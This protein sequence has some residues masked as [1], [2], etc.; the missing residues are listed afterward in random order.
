MIQISKIRKNA[1]LIGDVAEK[2]LKPEGYKHYP[3]END[4]RKWRGPNSQ[5][6]YPYFE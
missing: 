4:N 2:I 5:F 3:P 1:D 6:F